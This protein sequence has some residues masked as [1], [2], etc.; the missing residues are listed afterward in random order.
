MQRRSQFRILS[1]ALLGM[2]LISSVPALAATET[3]LAEFC[4]QTRCPDGNYP[5]G[6]LVSDKSGNLYG[7]TRYG[8]ATN[9]GTV[10]VLK[11]TLT[12]YARA[13]TIIAS[14]CADGVRCPDGAQPYGSLVIDPEGNLYGTTSQGGKTGF[15]TVYQ[16]KKGENK[17]TTLVSMCL[18][19]DPATCPD[20]AT[21]L[22]GLIADKTGNLY[23]TAY[24]GGTG[25][26]VA[27]TV[28]RTAAG[29]ADTAT[30]LVSFCGAPR[31]SCPDGA[32]PMAPLVADMKGNLYGTTSIGG[33]LSGDIV[34]MIE[35]QGAGAMTEFG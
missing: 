28:K 21:P 19:G 2:G 14:F 1:A 24:I 10:Y 32:R 4:N 33:S 8:G 7:I 3:V 15:G 35:R 23:G 13:P 20:G 5:W 34:F 18:S 29:Y 26:G 17:I 12:G 25:S 9:R 6:G 31:P 30:N 16:V 22:A 11:K 27:F